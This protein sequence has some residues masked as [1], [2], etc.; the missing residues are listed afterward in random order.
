MKNA[1]RV[2]EKGNRH[3]VPAESGRDRRIAIKNRQSSEGTGEL[4]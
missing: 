2:Q 3:K 4:S 1:G